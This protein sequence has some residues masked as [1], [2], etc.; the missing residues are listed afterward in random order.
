MEPSTDNPQAQ[1]ILVVEDE[2]VMNELVS[3]VLRFHDFRVRSAFTGEEALKTIAEQRPDGV[4]LDIMLPGVSGYEVCH[5]I[6]CARETN[7]LPVVMLTALD[8]R[9]DRVRGIRVGADAYVTKPFDP[10]VLIDILA[11]TMARVGER[12][13][14]GLRGYLELSFQ[15][16]L[17]YLVEVNDLLLGLYA[18][19]PLS[20]KEIQEIRY[21]L[22]EMGK[23]AVEWGN[24]N[25]T[26]LLIHM[27]YTLSEQQLEFIIRDQGEGFDPGNV[28]HAADP[29]DPLAHT[30]VR[31][32]LGMRE[33]G[34]GIL[35]SRS[36]M[37][38]VRYNV[39]GN[40]VT[41]I[42]RFAPA[43]R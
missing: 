23:N 13:A 37:D 19:S 40:E 30:F 27:E 8:R 6:K 10:E 24:R 18:Q 2:P 9:D 20:E 16:D 25:R 4:L 22:L 36:F 32:K 43:A 14:H 1:C 28:P 29:G 7:L 21:C 15:S 17:E 35:L 31:E 5:Q 41:L 39:K 3:E 34:F 33:G 11:K 42:K 26:D 38:E 12:V